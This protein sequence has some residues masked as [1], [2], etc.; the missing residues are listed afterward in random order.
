MKIDIVLGTLFGDEGKGQ[1]VNSLATKDSLV[2]R[3]NGGHQVG[4]TVVTNKMEH[5]FSQIGAGTFQGASTYISHFCTVYPKAFK[6]EY[7]YLAITLLFK[8]P[9]IRNLLLYNYFVD[10]FAMV[11]TP[12]DVAFNKIL[13]GI[14]GHGT[15]GTGFGATIERNT[16]FVNLYAQDL[17][18][19]FVY[20]NKIKQVKEFYQR[21][22]ND[23]DT[24][25]KLRYYDLIDE[26]WEEWEEALKFYKTHVRIE[27]PHLCGK[28]HIIFEGGQG[29][30][31]DQKIGFFPNVTRSNTTALNACELIN[32]EIKPRYN[33]SITTTVHYVCRA[34]MTRHGE[35]PFSEETL[36][37]KNNETETN[38]LNDW[39]GELRV[40]PMN[41]ELLKHAITFN[42]CIMNK[43]T[44]DFYSTLHVTC[45]DQLPDTV[46]KEMLKLKFGCMPTNSRYFK[47]ARD[48]NCEYKC[49]RG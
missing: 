11:T 48:W 42:N 33:G 4:H 15:T 45:F 35:G 29:I 20:Q 9:I 10:P 37:L 5:T 40:A 27:R 44:Q 1:T 22:A 7:D 24:D 16:K 26:E 2:I 38:K 25:S 36:E 21:S 3:H 34:Y 30:M 19:D 47:Y 8:Q 39:Q 46:D 49:G 28:E 17:L 32:R 18:C 14:Y 23:L 12:Y 6:R 43:Y 41:F 31:L 13:E